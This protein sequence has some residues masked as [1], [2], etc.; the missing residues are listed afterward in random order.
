M[1]RCVGY[2]EYHGKRLKYYVFGS[3]SEGFG[4]EITE[5]CVEKTDRMVSRSFEA[6]QDFAKQLRNGLVFPANLNEIL[7]DHQLENDTD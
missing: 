1:R 6:A 3:R 2:I 5:T 4:V 7:D